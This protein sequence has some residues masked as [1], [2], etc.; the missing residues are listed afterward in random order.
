MGEEVPRSILN[1]EA[2]ESSAFIVGVCF[3]AA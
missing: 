2:A 3:G 1:L